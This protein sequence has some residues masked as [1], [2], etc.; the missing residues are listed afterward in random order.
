MPTA[1]QKS[2]RSGPGT[3]AQQGQIIMEMLLLMLV[4][5]LMIFMFVE[6][7]LIAIEK[8]ETDR[9]S[10]YAARVWAVKTDS[11]GAGWDAEQSYR[12]AA[13]LRGKAVGG[14][15]FYE[16]QAQ[17]GSGKAPVDQE[18]LDGTVRTGVILR[19]ALPVIMPFTDKFLGHSIK[20]VL[21][22]PLVDATE[23]DPPF[24]PADGLLM[25]SH[26]LRSIVR[27]IIHVPMRR[28]PIEHPGKYDNDYDDNEL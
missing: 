4:L 26:G 11:S 20:P 3:G 15:F 18:G 10:R 27:A 24:T 5:L 9:I 2:D 1:V 16:I 13:G 6:I 21:S 28:E 12:A 25:R 14:G 8:H 17:V 23:T 19:T 22:L 7:C